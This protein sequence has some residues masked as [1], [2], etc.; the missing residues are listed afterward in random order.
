MSTPE[1]LTLAVQ[2]A[3][4]KFS[5]LDRKPT[6]A[7]VRDME[8]AMAPPLFSCEEFDAANE[9]NN[10]YGV[11]A[12]DSGYFDLYTVAFAV[13]AV[14][15]A[16]A[17]LPG[18]AKLGVIKDLESEFRAKK[19]DRALYKAADRACVEFIR[20]AVPETWIKSMK[21]RVLGYTAV[22]AAALMT[23]L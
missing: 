15:G 6:G 10:L 23:H 11:I 19:A 13:P 2:A 18:D 4:E 7:D 3:M 17:I 22:T 16:K 12:S 1:E 9:N 21:H 20:H 8:E 14:M 5:P